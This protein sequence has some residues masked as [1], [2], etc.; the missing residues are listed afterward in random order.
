MS[1]PI[2]IYHGGCDD[3]FASAYAIWQKHPLWTFYAGVYQEIPPNV[4][5]FD[6]YLVDFSYK[7]P[8]IEEMALKAKSV[9]V[10]DHHK[11]AQ[12]DLEPL[13]AEG[14][15]DGVFDMN[16]CGAVLTWKWFHGSAPP[17]FFQYIEDR[18]LWK[19]R[20]PDTDEF[21]MALRS[22]P[23]EFHVWNE[24]NVGKLTSEG[25][26][27]LRYYRQL[28][29]E[30]KHRVR[31]T[32]W[33]DHRVAAV[34]CPHFMASEVA[35]EIAVEYDVA[36]G[37]CWWENADGTRTFSLRSRDDFDV[38]EVA[39]KFGGGGHKNSAGFRWPALVEANG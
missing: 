36:F 18:D 8:V 30:A 13:L 19:R 29:D 4:E 14:V 39:K 22:Y 10:I 32:H 17:P 26:H 5:G 21:T 31:F 3:G 37:A 24:L 7:R 25:K 12:A 34:N 11:T 23:Q 6:V 28:V 1:E 16:H 35:G 33:G 38:S 15:I 2:V 20:L 9:T 27:I